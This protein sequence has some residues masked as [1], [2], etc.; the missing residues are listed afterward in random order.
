MA[1]LIYFQAGLGD[2]HACGKPDLEAL[3]LADAFKG[4]SCNVRGTSAG[5]PD[6]DGKPQAGGVFRP[7]PPEGA[8]W[9]PLGCWPPDDADR[10]KQTWT[11]FGNLY[12]GHY[13]ADPP[14]PEDLRNTGFVGGYAVKLDDGHEWTVPIA[15]VF[16]TGTTLPQRLILGPDDNWTSELKPEF[17]EFSR[18]AGEFYDLCIQDIAPTM[19]T[20]PVATEWADFAVAALAINYHIE[21][22]GASHLGL[23]GD[24]NVWAILRC[25][26]DFPAIEAAAEER[27]KKTTSEAAAGASTKPGGAAGSPATSPATPT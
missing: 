11:R 15:R 25:T 1:G 2:T 21:R 6:D 19:E 12:V 4:R 20:V 24:R 10:P 16:P 13:T 8:K 27:Q 7:A 5:P 26:T 9:P 23:L 14:T 3:G 17:V 22:R 18:R